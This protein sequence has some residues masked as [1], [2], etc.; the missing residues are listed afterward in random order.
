MDHQHY[1][2]PV[3]NDSNYNNYDRDYDR[4][5]Y[6]DNE[7]VSI[8][9]W[10][11]VIIVLAIPIINIIALFVLAFGNHNKNLKNFAKAS[12]ILGGIGLL[13]AI[14]VSGCSY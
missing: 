13:F 12:L 14:L 10:I 6:V 4:S 11:V 2:V 5:R 7:V 8:G 1:N 3:K 9:V